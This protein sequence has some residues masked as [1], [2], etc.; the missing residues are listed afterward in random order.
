MWGCRARAYNC[1]DDI[2]APDTRYLKN[3]NEWDQIVNMKCK[4]Y[5]EVI[6]YDDSESKHGG[7]KF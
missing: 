3:R 6:N 2:L 7:K 1:V 4:Q 5:I